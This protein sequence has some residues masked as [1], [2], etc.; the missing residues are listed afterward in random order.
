MSADTAAPPILLT[1]SQTAVIVGASVN[2]LRRAVLRGEVVPVARAGDAVNS[3]IL[4][5][6]DQLPDIQRVLTADADTGPE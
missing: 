1:M 4:F 5:T 6:V 3:P 2:R